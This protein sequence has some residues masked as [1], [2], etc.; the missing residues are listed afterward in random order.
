MRHRSTQVKR[1]IEMARQ[2]G[3]NPC[4]AYEQYNQ[5]TQAAWEEHFAK[6]ADANGIY[7]Q[8]EHH[9]GDSWHYVRKDGEC[10]FSYGRCKSGCR[11]FWR[12]HGWVWG[13]TKSDEDDL[14]TLYGWADSEDQ[15]KV[16][17]SAAIKRLAGGRRTVVHIN[18]G[19]ASVQLKEINAA[20]R[21]KRWSDAPVD[22]SD[23]HAVEYL[24]DEW[25]NE[26]R[27]T[28]KTAK[29]I[30]YVKDTNYGDEQIGFAPRHRV[31]D[32]WPGP[33]W[34]ELR[35]LQDRVGRRNAPE[36]FLKPQP[37]GFYDR[38]PPPP[39][40]N[41]LQLKAEMAAAHPDKGGTSAAFIAARKRYV[42]ARRR[43][44]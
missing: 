40:I 13:H 30:F 37:P 44:A 4:W 26:F 14:P 35:D 18:H 36:F 24:Y 28:K 2:A 23:T 31:A 1:A 42:E 3:L 38:E 9:G 8:P 41:L 19:T 10:S 32:D 39:V 43:I 27:I 6:H 33:T 12:V 7:W 22:G 25:G 21:V 20:K 17:G 16:E 15:A 29:R 34:R 5:F 11:W